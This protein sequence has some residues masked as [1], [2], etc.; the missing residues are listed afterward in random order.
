M[1]DNFRPLSNRVLVQKQPAETKTASG[2]YLPETAEDNF[3]F[4]TIIAV[5]PG[6]IT[7]TG[8]AIPMQ[9]QVGNQIY[10]GKYNG[11]EVAVNL[12]IIREDEIL[13]VL[14]MLV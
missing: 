5:G 12:I 13:G 8:H 9:V 10:F 3:S 11:T 7:T 4:G 1:F 2:L 14:D 6:S